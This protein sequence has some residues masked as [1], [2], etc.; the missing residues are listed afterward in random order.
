MT[1]K[2]LLKFYMF[3]F[4]LLLDPSKLLRRQNISDTIKRSFENQDMKDKECCKWI[5]KRLQLSMS[6]K[7]RCMRLCYRISRTK[8]KR[9]SMKNILFLSV[10]K[11]YLEYFR[12]RLYIKK[13]CADFKKVVTFSQMLIASAF[14]KQYKKHKSI[15]Q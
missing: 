15:S 14:K 12:R 7:F 10:K 2:V 9:N 13:S 5:S 11:Y 6:L 8:T 3:I 1:S 4:Q